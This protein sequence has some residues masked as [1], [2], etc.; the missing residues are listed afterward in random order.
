MII[1]PPT[2]SHI[3][4]HLTI[5][6]LRYILILKD[7]VSH[8]SHGHFL[9]QSLSALVW[10]TEMAIALTAVSHQPLVHRTTVSISLRTA[11]LI[12]GRHVCIMFLKCVDIEQLQTPFSQ[13][14]WV[15]LACSSEP[16]AF[17]VSHYTYRKHGFVLPYSILKTH[18]FVSSDWHSHGRDHPW[19]TCTTLVT[20]M[21]SGG[22]N[23]K[24][25]LLS[26]I[27]QP[28]FAAAVFPRG[29]IMILLDGPYLGVLAMFVPMV[30]MNFLKIGLSA[31]SEA[32]MIPRCNSVKFQIEY[33]PYSSSGP[34][35]TCLMI[36]AI[37]ARMPTE[38]TAT[39]VKR[40]R[41]TICSLQIRGV[42]RRASNMS[43]R[44]WITTSSVMRPENDAHGIFIP[45][46]KSPI[47][48]NVPRL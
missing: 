8:H 45:P 37:A 32:A 30:S 46:L 12:I 14:C 9:L 17:F 20:R 43:E 29:D 11:R 27:S 48:R 28:L 31:G 26:S 19:W 24:T 21:L 39:S 4:N 6:I 42:G 3:L 47:L 44:I 15:C 22:H 13:R 16:S 40:A 10:G 5:L 25:S 1:H 2:E 23:M 7:T 38:R 41:L 35:L 33:A 36:P 34:T 18:L